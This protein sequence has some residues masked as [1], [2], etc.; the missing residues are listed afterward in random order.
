METSAIVTALTT[1]ANNMTGAIAD[2]A[3]VALTV[4]GAVMAWR[5]GVKFFKSVAK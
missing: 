2:I 5:F 1:V 4:T 3:P